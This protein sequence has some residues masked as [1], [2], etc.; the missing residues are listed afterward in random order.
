MRKTSDQKHQRSSDA[1][2]HRP[3]EPIPLMQSPNKL[4]PIKSDELEN[5]SLRI[6]SE[7]TLKRNAMSQPKRVEAREYRILRQSNSLADAILVP[8][9][10]SEH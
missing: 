10:L 4:R 5:I 6:S 8:V 2:Q 3:I 1:K 7:Q 9:I